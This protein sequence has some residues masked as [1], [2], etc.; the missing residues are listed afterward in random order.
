MMH[1]TIKL[2]KALYKRIVRQ[3]GHIPEEKNKF[4]YVILYGQLTTAAPIPPFIPWDGL[5][6]SDE[7]KKNWSRESDS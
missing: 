5:M 4:W 3:V 6:I 2:N 7:C 1:G